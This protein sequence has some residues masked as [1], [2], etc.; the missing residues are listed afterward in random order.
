M[1]EEG[2]ESMA[3][4]SERA[5]NGLVKWNWKGRLSCFGRLATV[6]ALTV[7]MTTPTLFAGEIAYA[8]TLSQDTVAAQAASGSTSDAD[9]YRHGTVQIDADTAKDGV[10][11]L[12]KGQTATIRVSPYIHKQ[13]KGCGK[14]GCPENCEA[15]HGVECFVKG[16]GCKCD[17]T[18][19][20][21]QA[22]VTT[23]ID[24][25]DVVKAGDVVADKDWSNTNTDLKKDDAYVTKNGTITLTAESVGTA[26]VTVAAETDENG[27]I[28]NASGNT[29]TLLEHWHPATKTYTVK[30]ESDELSQDENGTYVISNASDYAKFVE[31]VNAGEYNLNAKLT[32]DIALEDGKLPT[33][34]TAKSEATAF[35]GTID[36]QG[37]K[38]SGITSFSATSAPAL[39]GYLNGG[40]I[41][42]LTLE[43]TAKVTYMTGAFVANAYAG[44]IESCTNAVALTSTKDVAGILGGQVFKSTGEVKI[45][46]CKNNA[47]VK[48]T[49]N[50]SVAAG[51]AAVSNNGP[52][53]AI[54]NCENSGAIESAKTAAGGI[55]GKTGGNALT[56]K[57]CS[58][59]GTV[60]VGGT[61][62]AGGLVAKIE[63]G[64]GSVVVS[65]SYNAGEIKSSNT[66]AAT[67]GLV[68]Q[69]VTSTNSVKVSNNFN[70]GKITVAD[71][72]NAKAG[73][74]FGYI[75][76]SGAGTT[77]AEN[78]SYLK[79]DLKGVGTN[80]KD[81]VTVAEKTADEL[82]SEDFAK[83]LGSDFKMGYQ[84]GHP[85]LS[86]EPDEQAP[87]KDPVI[88]ADQKIQLRQ[89]GDTSSVAVAIEGG[90]DEWAA[91]VT[92]IKV[93]PVKGDKRGDTTE[94]SGDR[95]TAA[96]NS[97]KVTRDDSNP[98][99]IIG[100]N[101]EFNAGA[102]SVPSRR[103]SKTYPNSKQYEVVI[104]A[105]G[106][107]DVTGT[108]SFYSGTS[109]TFKII[110]D[111][112][113]DTST[114]DD[115]TVKGEWTEDQLKA[116]SGYGF[117]NGS[118]QCGMTGFR[119]F[120]GHGVPVED[121]MEAAGVEP[122]EKDSYL[123]DTADHYGNKQT[124]ESLFGVDRYFLQ[125]IY[126]DKDVK[127][128]YAKLVK[129]DDEAGSTIELRKLL[130]SKA[131]E[132]KSTV[133]PM[134]AVDYNEAVLSG[135]DVATATLPD[136]LNTKLSTT[137]ALENRYRFI[138]G[139]KL[140]KDDCTVTFNAN[141][142]SDVASQTVQS[143]LM[144]ST[145]NTT[146]S[147][148]Y[149]V[150][151][152]YVFPNK[153][154][155]TTED[156]NPE[157]LTVPENPTRE[158]YTFAGWY[159]KDGTETGDWGEKFDFTANSGTVDQDTQ[160][161]A[162]WH[163]D[164]ETVSQ[165]GETAQA[166]REAQYGEP[167][168]GDSSNA[169]QHVKVT[170]AFDGPVTVTDQAALIN[171]LKF[172]VSG[173]ENSTLTATADGNNLVLDVQLGFALMA[174]SLNVSAAGDDGILD[175]VTVD[176]KPVK[177]DKIKTSVDT[178]LA[179]EAVSVVKG[180][181]DTPASTTYKV[182]HG[183]NVRSMNH[184]VWLTNNGKGTKG[185]S[186]LANTADYS[187]STSAHHHMWFK[188]TNLDSAKSI[189]SN[190]SESLDAA[191][192]TV[193]DNGDG[194]FT[195]TAK[196]AKQGEILGAANYTDSFFNA[197]GIKLGEDVEDAALPTDALSCNLGMSF[198][199]KASQVSTSMG[200][201]HGGKTTFSLT[202]SADA[203]ADYQETHEGADT[204]SMLNDWIS[205]ITSVTIDG[206]TLEGKAFD[207]WKDQ[208]TNA[209]D[210]AGKLNYYELT[211][212]GKS[213]TLTLPIALFDTSQEKSTKNIVIESKGFSTVSGDVTF[214]SLNSNEVV[215][216]I[217]SADGSKVEKTTTLTMDQL[218]NLPVQSG[219]TTAANCG[220]A[221]LR[222]YYSE[223]VLLTDVLKA[224]GVNFNSGMTLKVRVNDQLQ[225]NGN[226]T[227]TEDGYWSQSTWT[228]DELMGTA[229]YYYPAMWDNTTKYDELGGKTIYEV[230]SENKNAWKGDD[231]QAQF[232]RKKLA[233]T[234]QQ[235]NPILAWSWNESVPYFGG[236]NPTGSYDGYSQQLGMRFLYGLKADANGI[237]VDDNTTFANT[238]GVFGI[239]ILGGTEVTEPS[240]DTDVAVKGNAAAD[241]SDAAKD[242]AKQAAGDIY[243]DVKNAN[244]PSGMSK[245]DA[246]KLADVAAAADGDAGDKV[247]ME[248]T[249]KVDSKKA[250][251]VKDDA[252]KVENA[253]KGSDYA[254]FDVT[255][256]VKMTVFDKNGAVK[257][258]SEDV[259]LSELPQN[260]SIAIKVDPALL[261]KF[262]R[263]AHVHDGK[264][265]FVTPQSIDR[266]N[267]IVTISL[268]DFST[269]AV[270]ASDKANVTIDGV[271]SFD[272]T[273]GDKIS[274]PADPTKDGYTFGGWYADKDCTIPFDF[275]SPV[276][277]ADGDIHIY[278]KWTK[279]E[280]TTPDTPKGDKTKDDNGKKADDAAAKKTA[281]KGTLANT[282]DRTFAIAGMCALAGMVVI[283]IAVALRRKNAR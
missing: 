131:V 128:T 31:K 263:I 217:L 14:T 242:Q 107:N 18:P 4:C 73:A 182:T 95:I 161:Y 254:Y 65:N 190:A 58:N 252:A 78:V 49:G 101:D 215:V 218:K 135:D 169:G 43:G 24:N 195:I 269:I 172:S 148:S 68:G 42:N 30:V 232:L 37:H 71:G 136:A 17:H 39:V 19:V 205:N 74:V 234:E 112:D 245:D 241:I 151:A 221:G 114:T 233:E 246:K 255:P 46:S 35:S 235:V 79:G 97:I 96:S 243:N 120:S 270:V 191:G 208:L 77:T 94:V 142:G 228:Y 149:W 61:G 98:V 223:G 201:Y 127:D 153:G 84:S 52:S 89:S 76:A 129:S 67:G 91:A 113:G 104:S 196:A 279:N 137:T 248:M 257:Q 6:A 109:K 41:K 117:Y 53:L 171:S 111:E 50:S 224:A 108:V 150:Y 273:Y 258:Q 40:T 253:V 166:Y 118:S 256:T 199:E 168:A 247:K 99:F 45:T 125:S 88:K 122:S 36:G 249:L 204:K 164:S 141:G 157:K 90:T 213:A 264:V 210:D 251:D 123:I 126:T 230:L 75:S 83:S 21:R 16:M 226:G 139:I 184:I 158:G 102:I 237:P 144:T 69:S 209:T 1:L 23:T 198:P 214:R 9:Q 134:I 283:G 147:S 280:S 105:E 60:T 22:K 177:L 155:G 197:T 260:V 145:E 186:I 103:G 51:I 170:V 25:Q 266:K 211:A 202:P 152:L 92:S 278:A 281:D 62:V 185:S 176:G 20:D 240:V 133:K 87:V 3:K 44:T 140:A 259:E 15:E 110:V 7:T 159:T 193:I 81:D 200:R 119:T 175:G 268:K 28:N 55:V 174:G 271:G 275:D 59:K 180:T 27:D 130:A 265:T 187:Q 80:K 173:G 206:T 216:R 189:V 203:L 70:A 262:V 64:K 277:E 93:T 212:G 220:M 188:F 238:Y 236:T 57:G 34:C 146:W 115:Q 244:T 5:G 72:E 222:T 239:D 194:T 231:E 124:Y 163:V 162:K 13:Y 143:N 156:A 167:P 132:E 12:K 282:G 85:I 181:K 54:S 276:T 66:G 219:Y 32:A 38:I 267:G 116:M 2:S 33:I 165:T 26:R 179:F 138:Y 8:E 261:K 47:A 227:T 225:S 86:W 272:V 160:L 106:Y 207:E 11:T 178:G 274:K 183:A 100:D 250:Q 154:K 48:T 29:S 10:I 192:Y 82:A 121:L 56:V 229:R 63:G